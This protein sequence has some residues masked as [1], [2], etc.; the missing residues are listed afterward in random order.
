MKQL[1]LLDTDVIRKVPSFTVR[2]KGVMYF[3]RGFIDIIRN[4]RP[5]TD[6]LIETKWMV[7][8]HSEF[9]LMF[10]EDVERNYYS[11]GFKNTG[12]SNA[13]IGFLSSSLFYTIDEMYTRL[14]IPCF[15]SARHQVFDITA[16]SFKVDF[17]IPIP[18]YATGRTAKSCI[19]YNSV[20]NSLVK[21][22]TETAA[23]ERIKNE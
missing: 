9:I 1:L 11:L 14:N 16:K 7:F 23:F 2:S 15:P 19:E 17:S 18:V 6:K 22:N 10:E 8:K 20:V 4:L 13:S 3:N 12:S 5:S 21:F